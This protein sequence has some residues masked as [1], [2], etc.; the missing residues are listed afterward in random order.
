MQ[1]MEGSTVQQN[2][3]DSRAVKSNSSLS[4]I[5]N[6]ASEISEK[7]KTNESESVKLSLT[8]NGK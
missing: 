6:S 3:P 2:K 1:K 5:P 7:V 4:K 8:K